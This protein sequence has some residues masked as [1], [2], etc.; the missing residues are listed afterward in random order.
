MNVRTRMAPSPT[1]NLHIGTAHTSLF[2]FLLARK[3]GGKFILRLD[4]T[5]AARNKTDFEQNIASGLEWLGL[6]WDEGFDMG[7]PYEPYRQSLRSEV[8]DRYLQQLLDDGKVYRC[9]CTSEEL[10]AERKASQERK[11]PVYQYSGKCRHLSKDEVN[12]KIEAGLSF[13]I[14]MRTDWVQED[15][16]V[17]DQIR[18]EIRVKASEI[19]DFIIVR[20][21]GSPLLLL[22]STVDDIEMEITHAL[23][24]EDMLNVS[25]RQWFI[26]K[27]LN[28]QMPK[29]A[30]KPFLYSMEGKKLSK[31]DGATSI[32]EFRSQGY[33]P[34]A[35][36]NYL[37]MVGYTPERDEQQIWSMEEM[38]ADFDF[39]N[40]QKSMPRFDYKKLDWVNGQ[41]IKQLSDE[42]FVARTKRILGDEWSDELLKALAP[43][44]KERMNKLSDVK[45]M[46]RFLIVDEVDVP[47]SGWKGEAKE[48]MEGALAVVEGL[49]EWDL[50]KLND[51]FMKLIEE[52]EWKV[53]HFF[54]NLRLAVSGQKVTP[55]INECVII[56]GREKVVE[57]LKRAIGRMNA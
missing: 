6:V 13:T 39:G 3:T 42:E 28:K 43:L 29:Y 18:G 24:G 55:P 1:G 25:F 54:M 23:R 5:D 38:I 50:E 52:K 34:E 14:R 16:V 2:N 19:G 41:Y 8:Y 47:E 46:A 48:Q 21:D 33:L 49:D 12:E 35:L 56:L 45:D 30:H 31:R 53:G 15:V 9:F 22:T 40:F 26:F 37:F 4:D 32:D 51:G 7:G 44:V 11:D 27:A 36:V 57:R 17:D 20:S 10:E